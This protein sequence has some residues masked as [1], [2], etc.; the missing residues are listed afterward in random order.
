MIPIYKEPKEYYKDFK[1]YEH[2]VFCNKP[3]NT[4]HDGTNQPVCKDCAKTHKVSELQ[5]S[6]PNYKSIKSCQKIQKK[7]LMLE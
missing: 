4:W 2:C 6:H 1:C 3:T 5:K 7:S